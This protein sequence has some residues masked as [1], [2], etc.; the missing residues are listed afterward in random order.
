MDNN[1][2]TITWEDVLKDERFETIELSLKDGNN[3]L[4]ARIKMDFKLYMKCEGALMS[5]KGNE[6]DQTMSLSMSEVGD[7]LLFMGWHEGDEA[8]RSKIRLRKMATHKLGKWF[9]EQMPQDDENEE[10]KN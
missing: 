10:K 6:K 3:T 1:K 9:L 5:L 7:K 4:T 2:K 8:I